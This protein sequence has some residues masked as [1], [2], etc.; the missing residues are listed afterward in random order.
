MKLSSHLQ[1]DDE[2][3]SLSST[4]V[5]KESICQVRHSDERTVDHHCHHT[6]DLQRV[7]PRTDAAHALTE[8]ALARLAQLERVAA[9]LEDVVGEGTQRGERKG[10]RE[11]GDVTELDEHLQVVFER[12][13]ILPDSRI[14]ITVNL[15]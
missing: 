6:H 12:V 9:D 5:G 4:K 15:Q 8:R 3:D 14:P 7:L 10:R 1:H 13:V 11:E 2:H